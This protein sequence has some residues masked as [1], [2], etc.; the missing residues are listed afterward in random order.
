MNEQ[1]VIEPRAGSDA[2]AL[3]Q[4]AR[5]THRGERNHSRRM[6]VTARADLVGNVADFQGVSVYSSLGDEGADAGDADQDAVCGQ[7]PQGTV[8]GHAGNVQLAYELIFRGH[9]FARTH[10]PGGNLPQDEMLDLQ[11]AGAGCGVG[12]GIASSRGSDSLPFGSPPHAG[13]PSGGLSIQVQAGCLDR[14]RAIN[15][16]RDAF[17][18]S[19]PARFG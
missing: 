13:T 12:H 1:G 7:L 11:V 17:S 16:G 2:A 19:L 10:R 14:A 5:R 8:G 3:G 4:L 6:L 9:P 18:V 15:A